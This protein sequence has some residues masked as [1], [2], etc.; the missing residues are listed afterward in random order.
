MIGYVKWFFGYGESAKPT[1]PDL[2]KQIQAEKDH[3]ESHRAMESLQKCIEQLEAKI[4]GMD[5][6]V[7]EL[8]SVFSG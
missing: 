5:G 1:N 4:E 3:L 2:E 7:S 8:E 6:E